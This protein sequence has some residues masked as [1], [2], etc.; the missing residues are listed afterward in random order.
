[1]IALS[2]EDAMS[3]IV[4]RL[5]SA[6][7][8]A[9]LAATLLVCGAPLAKADEDVWPT[10]REANFGDRDIKAEDGFVTLDAP[11]TAEDAAVVPLTARVPPSVKAK[12]KS[13]TLIIDKNPNPVVAKVRFGPAAGAGGERSFATRV[14]VDNFSHVRAILETED[15][16]LHMATKFVQAAGGCAAM[17][18]KDPDADTV[19]L[20]KTIV[21]TFSPA[22]S[23]TPLFEGL[24]MIKHPNANGMQLDINTGDYIPARFVKEVVVKRDGE[25]VFTMDTTFSISTNPNFRFT[26]GRGTDNELEVAITDTDGTL[27]TGKSQP[28]GS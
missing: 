3:G 21:K 6:S 7:A 14:R 23:S 26:F 12:L 2:E 1:M 24:V 20:G 4:D 9:A 19:G 5:M 18:A 17:Q 8:A 25:L 15:G 28:S 16:T 27:F 13:L 10:L 11:V 22:L